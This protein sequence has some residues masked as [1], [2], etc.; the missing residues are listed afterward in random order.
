MATVK[1]I[2]I[3][4]IWYSDAVSYLKYQHDE[5]T[6]KPILDERGNL[7]LRD[8]YLLEGIL[9]N[10]DSFGIECMQTNAAFGKNSS[11]SEIKAHHYIISFDPRDKSENG[12]TPEKAQALGLE[13]ARAAFPGHQAIV[14]THP[15]GHNGAGNIHVHIVINSVRK[16]AVTEPLFQERKS[17]LIAGNKHNAS[18]SFMAF[19][20]Q[21]VMEICQREGLYQVDLLNS[22]K[23]CITDKEYWAQRRGQH[24]LDQEAASQSQPTSSKFETFLGVVRK[25][26][27]SVL[28]DSNSLEQYR[29]KL[30]ENY[31]IVLRESR[32]CFSYL[33]PDRERPIRARRLGTDFDNGFILSYFRSLEHMPRRIDYYTPK[34]ASRVKKDDHS[35]RLIVDLQSLVKA[36]ENPYYARKVKINNLK[37]MSKTLAFL[38]EN[39]L[40]T[41][42]ELTALVES[43]K[44]DLQ[45]KHTALKATEKDLDTT[46]L[47]I[48]YVGQYL[49]NKG[50]YAEYLKAKNK[51]EFRESH[52]SKLALY[53]AARKQ[54]RELTHDKSI[55]SLKRLKEDKA[56][57]LHRKNEQYAD[58]SFA[59]SKLKQLQTVAS[60]VESMLGIKIS[61]EHE[62]TD[63]AK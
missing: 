46:N 1:H 5:F 45:E 3:K 43:T 12:L 15:D 52:V 33:L 13:L 48:R 59:R 49:S 26:L 11:P 21:R 41:D 54:I 20:K 35:I 32:G 60:N 63:R 51:K 36:C 40:S 58:Y 55:P 38:Q 42:A 6:N 30:F 24:K 31:G 56:A 61:P 57:L 44:A 18:D 29:E 8:Y 17:D 7:I 4:N 62:P 14:C 27:T 47:L 10:P 25:Q 28:N 19:F 50:T 16:E 22:A 2:K 9:C 37:E 23:I 39:Q 34:D 53:E